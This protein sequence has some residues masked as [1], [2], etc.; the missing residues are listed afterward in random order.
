MKRGILALILL[1]IIFIFLISLS[2]VSSQEECDEDCKVDKAYS[3]L[4]GKVGD[5]STLTSE[6]K[7]FSLMALG[8]CKDDVLSDSKYK[9]DIKF[10]A[11]AIL[12]LKN[13]GASTD[14]PASWLSSQNTTSTDLIWYLQIESNEA[15]SCTIKYDTSEGQITIGTDK[16]ISPSPLPSNLRSCLSL[17]NDNYWLEISENCYDKEFSIKCDKSFITNLLY[18]KRDSDSSLIYVSSKTQSASPEGTIIEKVS[19]LCFRQ[20]A[21]CNY[22]GSLWAAIAL[23]SLDY[24]VNPFLPYLISMMDETANK[25]YLPEAFLS[26][27]TGEFKTDLLAKQKTVNEQYYWDESGDKYYDTALAL[28][29]FQYETPTE[30]IKS[31]DW[32]LTTQTEEG[33][34]NNIRNTAFIL[35][36]LWPEKSPVVPGVEEEVDCEDAGYFCMSSISCSEAGGN[37]LD[38][39]CAGTYVCCSKELKEETCYEKGGEICTEDETCDGTKVD[40]S[41]LRNGEIC[42][43][44][45]CE[46]KKEP[47][48]SDCELVGGICR[49][50]CYKDEEEIFES[51]EITSDVCCV[52]K[53]KKSYVGIIILGILIF[54]VILGIIFRKKL[55]E[56][57]FKLKSKRGKGGPTTT[58]FGG[59]RPGFPPPRPLLRTRAPARPPMR[60]AQKI[61]PKPHKEFD[62]VLKKLKEMGK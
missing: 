53:E 41:D 45:S 16:K 2:S 62:D 20:G 48:I 12:G 7:V 30:K 42:C 8:K 56:L 9:S 35:H 52:K 19:S 50:S 5:C 49:I 15:T 57:W 23:D 17:A 18:K 37:V 33:C 21:S 28:Y 10:T 14:E 46:E 47:K 13:S 25:K 55:R 34:W 22:E 36:S 61:T 31:K 44:G 54:L 11:Q 4:S 43:I 51:C 1:T 6:E 40:A 60:T 3:C 24:D 27:L 59:P 39:Y 26:I 38:Y 29:P 58:G 32:L